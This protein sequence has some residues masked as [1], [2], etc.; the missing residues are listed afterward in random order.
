MD[1]DREEVWVAAEAWAS[2]S[3]VIPRPGHMSAGVE[4]DYRDAAISWEDRV[5]WH[6]GLTRPPSTASKR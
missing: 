5:Q 3:G 6:H 2:A 4:E 1:S